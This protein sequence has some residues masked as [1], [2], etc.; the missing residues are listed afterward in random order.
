APMLIMGQTGAGKSWLASRIYELK[1]RRLDLKGSFVEINC[2]TLRGDNA[3]STLFGHKKG[4]FTGAVDKRDGLLRRAD[5]GLLFLDEIGE[6]GL[7]EQA[8]LLRAIE[9]KRFF[10]L[11]ADKEEESD[12]QLIAGTNRDLRIEVKEGRFRE[13]LFARINLWT[14]RLPGLA[15]R[16]EDIE[17]NIDYELKHFEA[18]Q[19]IRVRFSRSAKARY[20][21]FALSEDASWTGNFRD[22][23]ASITRMATLAESGEID[24]NLVNG[25]I[26]TLR[27]LWGDDLLQPESEKS[28]FSRA[29]KALTSAQLSS[30]QFSPAV[31]ILTNYLP[32]SQI[33][34]LDLMEQIELATTIM[35]C[36]ESHSAAE[37]GRKLYNKSRLK[38]KKTNDGARVI[39]MLEKHGL[40]FDQLHDS[41]H[42]DAQTF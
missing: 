9:E 29:P 41:E 31:A 36:L 39:T 11:G 38:R 30:A 34:S 17:P 7:D 1:R 23:N 33:E 21:Q 12:F 16:R 37:A 14:Y 4:A 15:E 13:D 8:M 25:E 28:A 22:L 10:P 40:S 2:A 5:R 19:G 3:M 26:Q 6:L 35:A 32:E 27:Y 24:D 20:L 18:G 42:Q